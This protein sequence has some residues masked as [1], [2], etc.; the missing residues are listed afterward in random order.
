MSSDVEAA[1]TSSSEVAAAMTHMHITNQ[2]SASSDGSTHQ[3]ATS[4]EASDSDGSSRDGS[5]SSNIVQYSA[6]GS[7]HEPAVTS[8]ELNNARVTP[9]SDNV[10]GAVGISGTSGDNSS[11]CSSSSAKSKKN[12]CGTCNKKVG[13]TGFPCRCGGLFCSLHR[14]SDTHTCTFNYKEQAQEDI[15]KNNPVVV[16]EKIK[17]I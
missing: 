5:E 7:L 6:A 8:Q 12:R 15:R 9:D 4:S 11:T 1:D 10:E 2:T 13:L 17:K 16:G 14:Y 3:Q